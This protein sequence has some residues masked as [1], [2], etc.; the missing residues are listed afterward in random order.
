MSSRECSSAVLDEHGGY[1]NLEV[2]FLSLRGVPVPA[3]RV[4][5]EFPGLH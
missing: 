5:K 3:Q 4:A 2:E 1:N